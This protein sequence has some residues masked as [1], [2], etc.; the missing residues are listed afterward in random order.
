MYTAGIPVYTDLNSKIESLEREEDRGCLTI[1]PPRSNIS[2]FYYYDDDTATERGKKARHR[3]SG[4]SFAS[5][6]PEIGAFESPRKALSRACWTIFIFFLVVILE[7]EIWSKLPQQLRIHR[8]YSRNMKNIKIV[9]QARSSSH[10]KLSI[11][12]FKSFLR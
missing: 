7:H 8:H 12:L 10:S 6:K 5:I 11:L 1:F 9:Q 3:E 4:C 2:A